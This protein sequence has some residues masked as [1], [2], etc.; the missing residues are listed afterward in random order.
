MMQKVLY[1][2]LGRD[3]VLSFFGNTG[4]KARQAYP[5]YL[6]EEKGIN[7]EKELSGVGLLRSHGG[8][9]KVQSMRKQGI[10]ALSDD[11]Q[12]RQGSYG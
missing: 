11:L 6:V 1:P 9:S 3:Y 2:W 5:E 4:G 8:W 7:L 10:K 12:R